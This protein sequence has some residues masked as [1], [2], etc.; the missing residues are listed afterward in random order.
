MPSNWYNL[1]KIWR[2]S[3]AL[4]S[5]IG[6]DTKMSLLANVKGLT[7]FSSCAQTQSKL[8][9]RLWA[10]RKNLFYCVANVQDST[11]II[12]VFCSEHLTES[13]ITGGKLW[14]T[15]ATLGC[16]KVQQCFEL[17]ANMLACSQW[18]ADFT[19]GLGICIA[20]DLSFG[21]QHDTSTLNTKP[22]WAWWCQKTEYWA[23]SSH[24]SQFILKGL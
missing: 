5:P 18:H 3:K 24:F 21:L 20:H 12:N 15:G 10:I 17:D 2:R 4:R 23:T 1:Y 6:I 13:N 8:R 11:R 9:F 7:V 22:S 19:S 16:T 14:P